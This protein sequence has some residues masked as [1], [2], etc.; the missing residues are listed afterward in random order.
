MSLNS[1]LSVAVALILSGTLTLRAGEAT[2]STPTPPE[3]T[4]SAPGP[5]PAI[6]A[7]TAAEAAEAAS[8]AAAASAPL[9]AQPQLPAGVAVTAPSGSAQIELKA[10]PATPEEIAS[11]LRLGQ[12]TLDRNDFIS[13]ELAFRRVLQERATVEQDREALLGLARVYRKKG[14]YIKGAAIYEKI[15]VQYPSDPCLPLVYL[16]LGRTHR[17]LGAYKQAIAR[18][19]SVIHSTLK[20]PDQG[21]EQ[22]RQL[23]RTAQ[24]ELAETHFQMGQYER[25][26]VFFSRLTLL[27][28]APEDRARAQFKSVYALYLAGEHEKAVAGLRGF[29]E[30]NPTD[31]NVPE[32]RYLLSISLRRLGRG[33]ESLTAALELLRVERERMTTDEKRWTYWQRKTGNQLANDFYEAGDFA[34]AMAIYQSLVNL[35]AEPSWR[36]PATYQLGLCHERLR[37]FDRARECY[38]TIIDNVNASKRDGSARPELADIAEMANWRL[39]HLSWQET[40]DKQLSALFPPPSPRAPLALSSPPVAPHDLQRSAAD[41]SH[42]VR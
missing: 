14:D 12:S 18:F 15:I 32:A 7:A 34:S 20:L 23:A 13:A 33:S 39:Q 35:G 6:H 17:A 28:L 3:T 42:L 38:Q 36:L 22:Y 24:F 25:A 10:V 26:T 5:T 2:S 30:L 19:Y 4:A 21:P 41:S 40:N 27:D 9:A 31:E 1:S 16:E 37:M 29:L 11:L 8:K